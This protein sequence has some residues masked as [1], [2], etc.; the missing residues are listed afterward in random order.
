MGEKEINDNSSQKM[1]SLNQER[2]YIVAYL[3]V[4]LTVEELKCSTKIS[5]NINIFYQ[6]L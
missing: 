4:R 1:K 2:K 3:Y 5:L 6:N